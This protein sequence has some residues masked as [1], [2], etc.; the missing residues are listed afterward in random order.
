MPSF[1]GWSGRLHE[2]PVFFGDAV[3]GGTLRPRSALQH[4]SIP[5]CVLKR[6]TSHIPVWIVRLHWLVPLLY[7]SI[8]RLL[9]FDLIRK[10][11]DQQIFFCLCFP[12]VMPSMMRELQMIG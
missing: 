5:I 2:I 8:H 4:N 10:V 1:R 7:H 11:E 12:Y 9:P 6:F 3:V